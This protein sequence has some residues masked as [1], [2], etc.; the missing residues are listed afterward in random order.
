MGTDGQVKQEFADACEGIRKVLRMKEMNSAFLDNYL[1]EL[2]SRQDLGVVHAQAVRNILDRTLTDLTN[3]LAEYTSKSNAIQ[4]A[5]SEKLK[6][7]LDSE[8]AENDLFWECL[9]ELGPV[10]EAHSLYDSVLPLVQRLLQRI[11]EVN[12]LSPESPHIARLHR[13]FGETG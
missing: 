6:A 11:K 8:R 12:P 9:A 13:L 1:K 5:V 4:D 2:D 3:A 10:I 7:K